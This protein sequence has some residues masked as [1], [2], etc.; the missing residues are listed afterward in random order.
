VQVFSSTD[1]G[2]SRQDDGLPV[3]DPKLL[4]RRPLFIVV[5]NDPQART[6]HYGFAEAELVYE[7]V[8][9]G[10]AVT[11]YTL[12][13]LAA[14]SERIGPVRSARLVNFYLTP[15]Y[16]GALVASG[17]GNDVR[18]W[19]KHKMPA[20]YLDIDLDDPG[21]NIYAFTVG[22]NYMTRM[23]TSTARLR[24]WLADWK[25]EQ[26]PKLSGFL[27]D[28]QAPAGAPA[29]TARIAYPAAVTWTYDPASGRYLRSMGAAAH[30]DA[31][32]GK[33]LSAANVVIQTVPH[34][35]TTYV[36]DSLGTTSIRIVTVGAGAAT[37]LRDG[38]AIRGR[39]QAG[40]ANMP[41]FF[42]PAGKP[43]ALKPGNTWFE[44][45]APE[46]A[47]TIGQQ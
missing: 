1:A 24:K 19:L 12:V 39:W 26:D 42:D 22:A 27:F 7:Y 34:E 44:L 16:G 21:N 6:A 25:V 40:D 45:V 15:Q 35:R 5:N 11:R 10:L 17:A 4:A 18:W 38:V 29:A 13:F 14:E 31:A 43:I 28:A 37:I 33:Q 3:S 41:E 8:M 36:E 30:N 2:R 46:T 47:V 32:T 23:Q 9:E 20:P